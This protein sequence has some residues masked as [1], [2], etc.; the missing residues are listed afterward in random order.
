[1]LSHCVS[2]KPVGRLLAAELTWVN[3]TSIRSSCAVF[4]S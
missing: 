3:H 4:H 1:M 2:E